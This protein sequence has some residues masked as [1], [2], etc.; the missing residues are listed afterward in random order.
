M[1]TIEVPESGWK[2]ADT[3]TLITG[4]SVK[5]TPAKNRPSSVPAML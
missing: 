3:P 1:T 5:L 2:R 4:F